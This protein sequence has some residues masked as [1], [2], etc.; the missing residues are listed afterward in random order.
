M[1]F[2][3]LPAGKIWVQ[4]PNLKMVFSPFGKIFEIWQA[5]SF[6]AQKQPRSLKI[7]LSHSANS[8]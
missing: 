4:M 3:V 6:L 5:Y 8:F 7:T 2:K 1:Q